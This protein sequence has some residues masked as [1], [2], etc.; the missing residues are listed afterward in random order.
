MV[1]EV[2]SEARLTSMSPDEAAAFWTVRRSEG[3]AD[4][5]EEQFREWLAKSSQNAEAWADAETAWRAFDEGGDDEILAAMRSHALA[6][7]RSSWFRSQLAAAAAVLLLLL[8][9]AWLIVPNIVRDAG[10]GMDRS[11]APAMVYASA[12]GE[13]KVVTLPDGSRVTLD[14]ASSVETRFTDASRALRLLRG[15]AFFDVSSD[16]RRP[17]SVAAGDREVL[18]LGTRFDVRLRPGELTVTLV[19]GSVRISAPGLTGSTI[20]KPGQQFVERGDTAIVRSA[21]APVDEVLGWQRGYVTFDNDTLAAAV[22]EI[23]RYSSQQLVV[24][25]QASAALRVT[26]RFRSGDA[27]RFGRTVGEIHPVDM[28]RR[29]PG[30]LELVPRN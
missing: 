18:A 1:R 20:L 26:G 15:R 24:R 12:K 28:V 27:E 13:V 8:A 30:H 21:N 14:A 29:G 17:F 23:N 10:P 16:P 9:S 11:A 3:L 19:E 25:D 7:Q 4:Y 6:A 22:A 5:E 2:T